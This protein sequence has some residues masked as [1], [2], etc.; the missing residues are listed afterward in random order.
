MAGSI[1]ADAASA[2]AGILIW[3]PSARA[4]ASSSSVLITEVPFPAAGA[5]ALFSMPA[6]SPPPPHAVSSS[7][8]QMVEI[9]ASGIRRFINFFNS[10]PLKTYRWRSNGQTYAK[11]VASRKWFKEVINKWKYRLTEACHFGYGRS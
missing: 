9:T 7:V 1:G 3:L 4:R 10:C 6:P 5:A 2:S 8:A 11:R